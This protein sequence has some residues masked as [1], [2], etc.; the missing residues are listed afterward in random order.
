MCIDE[1]IQDY[2]IYLFEYFLK[3]ISFFYVPQV[4]PS[5]FEGKYYRRKELTI[6]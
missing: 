6:I 3:E 2:S 5:K 1:V 4:N